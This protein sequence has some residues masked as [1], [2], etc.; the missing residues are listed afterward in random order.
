MFNTAGSSGVDMYF[1]YVSALQYIFVRNY[2]TNE[3]RMRV[4]L[5]HFPTCLSIMDYNKIANEAGLSLLN[6]YGGGLACLAA[7]GTKEGKV[8]IYRLDSSEAKLMLKTKSGVMYGA[9]TSFSMQ[10]NGNSFIVGSSTG[11]IVSFQLLQN[12][13]GIE[14]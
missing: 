8:L 5:Q 4:A 9:V 7:V 14:E 2:N 10:D 12:L 13:I 6:K 1:C 11:E 3:T